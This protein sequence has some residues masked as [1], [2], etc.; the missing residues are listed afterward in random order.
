R[1]AEVDSCL[2]RIYQLIVDQWELNN[3]VTDVAKVVKSPKMEEK[4]PS[5]PIV[6]TFRIRL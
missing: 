3:T 5:V 2:A 4:V 6:G 1:L